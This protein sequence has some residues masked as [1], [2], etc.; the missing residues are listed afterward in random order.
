MDSNM[1]L[2]RRHRWLLV[3]LL[4][5]WP[6]MFIAT[7]VPVH[8]LGARTGM[9][10]QTMHVLAYLGLSVLGWLAVSPQNKVNWR[11]PKVWIIL[12]AVVWY[13]VMDELLQG[14]VG[15]SA[16]ISDFVAN[17]V[18]V[19]IGLAILTFLSLWPAALLVTA[20][21][22][23]VLSNMARI[24]QIV[25]MPFINI[26]FHFAAYAGFTLVWIQFLQPRLLWEL[27]PLRWFVAALGPPFVLL[28]TVK[29][30]APLFGRPLWPIYCATAASGIVSAAAVSRFVCRTIWLVDESE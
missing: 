5:Y 19:L 10:D 12:A 29:L 15:R 20:I 26:M 27:S 16:E 1:T 28:L 7:H 3:A 4:V 24:D 13:S 17:M 9:S 21:F 8:D 14:L 2:S 23:F 25:G 30:S 6:A 22:T 11:K 18:G